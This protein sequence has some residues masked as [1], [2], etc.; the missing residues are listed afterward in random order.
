VREG[1]VA[2]TDPGHGAVDVLEDQLAH[3][4]GHRAKHPIMVSMASSLNR[5][6]KLDF[7]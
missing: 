6:R 5:A 1:R 2:D 4:G 7:Q 3:W